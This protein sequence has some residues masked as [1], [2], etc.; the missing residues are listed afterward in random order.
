MLRPN[1]FIQFMRLSLYLQ[2]KLILWLVIAFGLL[3]LFTA[4]VGPELSATYS[5]SLFISGAL[6][7]IYAFKELH[8]KGANI[9]YLTLP[10]TATSR[11]L[12]IWLLTGPLY[13]LFMT[14]LY[15]IGM[16]VHYFAHTFWFLGNSQALLWI[17][18]QYLIVN[19]L[20]LF[21]SIIF[22]KLALVKTLLS[23]LI[24]GVALVILQHLVQEDG[25]SQEAIATGHYVVWAVLGIAA[26]VGAYHRLKRSELR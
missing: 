21:G 16:L 26:W 8:D 20:F 24:L 11:Y 14:L 3:F 7:S 2:R 17:G 6:L 18:G 13:W 23:L 10:I 25:L 4:N 15:S 19:A 5:L 9:Q 22:R 12:A 1:S